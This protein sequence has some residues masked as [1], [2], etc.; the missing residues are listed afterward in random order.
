MWVGHR[1]VSDVELYTA[2]AGNPADPPLLVIHGGPDWDHTYL[3][4]PLDR[5]ADSKHLLLP[6]LRGCGR[7]ARDLPA[8]SYRPDAVVADLLAIL[9]DLGIGATDV[10]G[11]SYGGLLAQ[12]LAVTAP[13][14]VRRLI[15]ASSSILPIPPDSYRDWPERNALA[16]AE[17]AVWSDPAIAGPER[18]RAAALA[19]AR[20]NIWR[21]EALPELFERLHA[22]WFSAE[23]DRARRSGLLPSARLED[24]VRSLARTEIPILLLH[25]RNDMIFPY[26]DTVELLTDLL[27]ITTH[28]ARRRIEYAAPQPRTR[29][30]K[31]WRVLAAAS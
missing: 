10:L 21:A 23:W 8:E 7:S 24:P 2:R 1:T 22:V 16:A 20:A 26:R 3:R 25:G 28:E 18:T 9:D 5:L 6:Y 31:V 15:I 11:F 19:G 13:G 14:C 29:S 30:R 17:T 4:T 27:R 12:R